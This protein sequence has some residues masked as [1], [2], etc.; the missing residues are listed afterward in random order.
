[1]RFLR[2][3]SVRRPR[4]TR[5]I[6]GGQRAFPGLVYSRCAQRRR[7]SSPCGVGATKTSSA[8]AQAV[9]GA[10]TASS[11]R[12]S[13]RPARRRYLQR[14]PQG[15]SG[16]KT[17][18]EEKRRRDG[19]RDR[20]GGESGGDDRSSTR[21][22]VVVVVGKVAADDRTGKF[23]GDQTRGKGG[24]EDEPRS[25]ASMDGTRSVPERDSGNFWGPHQM[26]S[27]TRHCVMPYVSCIIMSGTHTHRADVSAA[28]RRDVGRRP[29]RS[30]DEVAVEGRRL[31]ARR[32]A[33]G[34]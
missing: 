14:R 17:A 5:D 21:R 18:R 16:R 10:D 15:D 12:L 22:L 3:I 27:R 25:S 2:P 24:N 26:L 19:R 34:A 4:R 11:P 32:A 30:T 13:C 23:L 9:G 28:Q 33:A 1:M 20:D 7:A 29:R 6:A 8:V 31:G